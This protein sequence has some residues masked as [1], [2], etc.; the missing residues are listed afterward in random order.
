MLPVDSESETGLR[1]ATRDEL[2]V[3]FT[4]AWL[5]ST[6]EGFGASCSTPLPLSP[7]LQAGPAGQIVGSVSRI[8]MPPAVVGTE[9][10]LIV[11]PSTIG[12]SCGDVVCSLST[13]SCQSASYSSSEESPSLFAET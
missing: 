1:T 3:S 11:S 2:I 10:N 12:P 6:L 4:L 8:V 13:K 7:G 5:H 9:H